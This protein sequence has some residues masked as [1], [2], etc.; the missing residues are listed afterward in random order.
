MFA[1]IF[2]ID[3]TTFTVIEKS[4]L[5]LANQETFSLGRA[6]TSRVGLR[7]LGL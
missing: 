6:R 3:T 2:K 4:L 5:C 1:T 7:Q